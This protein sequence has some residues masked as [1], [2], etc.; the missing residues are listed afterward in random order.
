MLHDGAMEAVGVLL[1]AGA[2]R[3][4]GG[5]KVLA[6]GG[7][8][9]RTAVAAL[10]DGGCAQVVVVL[11]AAAEQAAELVPDGVSVVVAGDWSR[12]MSA[13]LRAGLRMAEPTAATHALLHLVDTPDVG[14][15]V[16]DRVLGS[17]ADLAR[18]AYRDKPG[19]PV[20]LARRHWPA[21]LASATGD[22]GARDFLRRHTD[23]V[24]LECG[25]L[26][27]GLDHDSPD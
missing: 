14:A 8:W 4:Y 21:V 13:S 12:G 24:F 5:P 15:D 16:V 1:A 18:A 17:G 20:L 2:G 10:V 23:V 25:D 9:L 7:A 26:A 6:H 11:G 22:H 19:H 27:T 3:R